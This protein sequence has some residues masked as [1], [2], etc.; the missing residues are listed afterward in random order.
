[1]PTADPPTAMPPSYGI[2][3]RRQTRSATKRFPILYESLPP[4]LQLD[5]KVWAVL[6]LRDH[7]RS[8]QAAGRLRMSVPR[9]MYNFLRALRLRTL[10]TVVLANIVISD[11]EHMESYLHGV[12]VTRWVGT[13]VRTLTVN[14]S[15][16]EL[17]IDWTIFARARTYMLHL[18]TISF[19]ALS[20]EETDL[21]FV[22][23]LKHVSLLRCILTRAGLAAAMAL[24]SSLCSRYNVILDD[25]GAIVGPYVMRHVDFAAAS[26]GES[27]VYA[28]VLGEVVSVDHLMV[29]GVAKGWTLQGD[30]PVNKLVCLWGLPRYIYAHSAMKDLTLGVMDSNIADVVDLLPTNYRGRLTV[31]VD[32]AFGVDPGMMEPLWRALARVRS[33]R[34]RVVFTL[35]ARTLAQATEE[36]ESDFAGRLA[37]SNVIDG[38][39]LCSGVAVTIQQCVSGPLYRSI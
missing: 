17:D 1:M 16:M 37:V 27:R 12:Q 5:I 30:A 28:E 18:E 20:L 29:R 6:M 8:E 3:T 34:V 4:E 19:V 33:A 14:G 35:R 10:R 7:F 22:Q 32:V 25:E 26:E 13:A 39:Q 15:G 9:A 31:S 38:V 36:M 24:L 11:N 2:I 21:A 23:G